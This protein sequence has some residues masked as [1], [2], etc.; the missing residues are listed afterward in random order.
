MLLFCLRGLS[1]ELGC[2]DSDGLDDLESSLSTPNILLISSFTMSASIAKTGRYLWE[3]L[4]VPDWSRQTSCATIL[5][6]CNSN[7]KYWKFRWGARVGQ[8]CLWASPCE[9]MWQFR[10][11]L[12]CRKPH[13]VSHPA[14]KSVLSWSSGR[15]IFLKTGAFKGFFQPE[16][17][18][19]ACSCWWTWQ[20]WCCRTQKVWPCRAEGFWREVLDSHADLNPVWLGKNFFVLHIEQRIQKSPVYLFSLQVN[21]ILF[22]SIIRILL[23]KLRSPDVGGNDQSQ[24]KWV[25]F[26]DITARTKIISLRFHLLKTSN[27]SVNII[28]F[29]LELHLDIV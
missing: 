9:S 8:N 6:N 18:W 11:V 15:R 22:I 14:G 1:W 25:I 17:H 27:C 12:D 26:L 23:Q 16:Q 7:K 20:N 2:R 29:N 4:F 24:Y 10:T 13:P 21:F 19:W 3:A 28:I 5:T